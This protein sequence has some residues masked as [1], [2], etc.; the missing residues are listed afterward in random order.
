M[1]DPQFD[2]IFAKARGPILYPQSHL[3]DYDPWE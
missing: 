3:Y 2:L 1:L